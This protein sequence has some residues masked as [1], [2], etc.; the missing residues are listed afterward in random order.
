[1]TGYVLGRLVQALVL[2]LLVS[3]AT[4]LLVHRAPGGPAL[5]ADPGISRDQA[6]E[7]A[8]TLGLD[9][10]LHRQYL[11]WLGRV[12][13]G[14]LGVSFQAGQPVGRLI[15]ERL[16][17]TLLLAGTGLAVAVVLAVPLGLLAAARRGSWL[18]HAVGALS[19]VGLSV[20]VFWLGLMLILLFAVRLRWLP[21]GGLA[22]LGGA[23]GAGDRLAHLLLP[24]A[25][26]AAFALAQ[27]T[28]HLRASLVGVLREDYVRTAW[29]KGL[30]R[31]R[32]WLRHALGNALLPMVTVVGLLLPQLAAGAAITETIFAWP[33]MGRLAV[34]AAFQRD[35]PLV[36][37]ITLVVSA[38]VV[39][40]NL[41][42]D[43]LYAWLDPRIRLG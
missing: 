10:P 17:A 6:R 43:L 26:V 15:A 14:R 31:R 8:R 16:P 19:V 3:A 18:D 29:A 20:P 42:T 35:Y 5:L 24:A 1:M 2:L 33:G 36:M 38:A 9:A 23:G 28:R 40:A 21:A 39:L 30:P 25:A 13:R 34:E 22:T 7:M 37:G 4:F 41:L 32:V 11:G 12:I 27:L